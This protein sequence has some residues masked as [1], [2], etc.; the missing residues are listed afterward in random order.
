[1]S[2]SITQKFIYFCENTVTIYKYMTHKTQHYFSNWYV[3]QQDHV[4]TFVHLLCTIKHERISICTTV[5]ILT[6]LHKLNT[7]WSHGQ[8]FGY[9]LKVDKQNTATKFSIFFKPSTYGVQ[10]TSGFGISLGNL[11]FHKIFQ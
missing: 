1:M 6:I 11:K 3:Q 10:S 5:K 2:L 7:Y 9:I 8:K 4:N